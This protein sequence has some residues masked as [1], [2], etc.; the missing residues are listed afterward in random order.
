MQIKA[1]MVMMA[2]MG[3]DDGARKCV[4][5]EAT[6]PRWETVAACDQA[7]EQE[8]AKYSNAN[9]PMIIAICQSPAAPAT[10]DA[11]DDVQDQQKTAAAGKPHEPNLAEKTI[12]LVKKA[13]P[14]TEG[15]KN[16]FQQPV[17]VIA[18]GYAWVARKLQRQ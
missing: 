18:N 5:L 13:I 17:H 10:A 8:L 7:S 9:Y 11:T 1:A 12:D 4:Q 3:C 15:I 16:A 14:T 2:I 6:E